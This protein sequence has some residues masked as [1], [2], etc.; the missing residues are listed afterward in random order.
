MKSH[1][2]FSIWAVSLALSVPATAHAP[3]PAPAYA[4]APATAYAPVVNRVPAVAPPQRAIVQPTASYAQAA[5]PMCNQMLANG[6]YLAMR[7]FSTAAGTELRCTIIC[8]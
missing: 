2:K 5:A 3:A 8:E 7:K 1:H 4:Q 6:C